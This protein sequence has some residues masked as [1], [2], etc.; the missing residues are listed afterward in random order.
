MANFKR[1]TK[2]T[3]K[4]ASGAPK[5]DTLG[6][7]S[8]QVKLTPESLEFSRQ[9]AMWLSCGDVL[10]HVPPSQ[11]ALAKRLCKSN[12]NLRYA[13]EVWPLDE[14]C[15]PYFSVLVDLSHPPTFPEVDD[16]TYNHAE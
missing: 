6:R 15:Q 4:R 1:T 8:L 2:K 13:V 11:E 16:G 10:L 9:V 3:N 5:I 7:I 14:D 12:P